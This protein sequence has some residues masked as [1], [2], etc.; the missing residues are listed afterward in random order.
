[1][2]CSNYMYIGLGIESLFALFC[3]NFSPG[4]NV[5]TNSMDT[6]TLS[7]P[8]SLHSHKPPGPH[9]FEPF[10][11]NVYR[12]FQPQNM[13]MCKQFLGRFPQLKCSL[14]IKLTFGSYDFSFKMKM[15]S[16]SKRFSYLGKLNTRKDCSSIARTRWRA[17]AASQL[18]RRTRYRAAAASH[19][20]NTLWPRAPNTFCVTWLQINISQKF[21]IPPTT[22]SYVIGKGT[23][24]AFEWYHSQHERA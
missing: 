6:L 21:S 24:Y 3:F 12:S 2:H 1:M 4:S 10:T 13:H 7:W 18:H 15:N 9:C 17:A 11:C 14:R 19:A 8:I 22:V 23:V 16:K 20:I 5:I